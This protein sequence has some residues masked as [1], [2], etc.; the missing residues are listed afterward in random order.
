MG[1]KLKAKIAPTIKWLGEPEDH[2]YPVAESYLS[3]IYDAKTAAN[4]T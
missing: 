2:G 3:L 1:T 4:F